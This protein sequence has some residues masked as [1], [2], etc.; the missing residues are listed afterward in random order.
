MTVGKVVRDSDGTT[1][2]LEQEEAEHAD[3][4]A[5]AKRTVLVDS[6]GD[7]INSGN[8]LNVTG[9][10]GITGINHGVKTVTTA[11]T[12]VVLA[13]ST[14]CKK[15][16]IQ[17]QTDNTGLISIGGTGVDATEA[18]GTGVILYP[19]DSYEIDV[20][21]L[22]DIFIDSTVNGEGVRYSYLT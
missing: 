8:P 21:N 16:T 7:V 13:A 11:G 17:A 3:I 4:T 6:T 18:T 19:G 5:N 2:D 20:D 12:D 15:V 14:V 10:E 22:E 1:I 9:G